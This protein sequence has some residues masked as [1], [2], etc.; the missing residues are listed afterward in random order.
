MLNDEML[1]PHGE[2]LCFESIL[3]EYP[4]P[5]LQRDSY[6]NLNGL[7][8]YAITNTEEFP[9]KYQGKIAVP[10]P[11]ESVLSQVKCTLSKNEYLFYKR[12]FSLQNFPI[13][14]QVLLHFMAV[15]QIC[16]LYL[17]DQK[18]FHHEG[19]YLPFC[20]N[21]K[22][23]LKKENCLIVRVVDSL[24][25]KFPYGKQRQDHHG[26]W[27]TPVSGIWQ[28]VFIESVAEDYIRELTIT[29]DYDAKSVSIICHSCSDHFHLSL[30]DP[31]GQ[32]LLEEENK[33]GL[34]QLKFS[35]IKSWSPEHP[36]LY[37]FVVKTPHDRISSYFGFRKFHVDQN[38]F[39]LNNRPYFIHAVLDQ[40]YYSDG[41][42]T[43]ASYQA[44]QDDLLYIRQLGFNAIR[45]HIKIEP[46][47]F[48]YLCDK[49]GILLLQDFVNNSPYHFLKDTLL[50]T[51][52]IQKL[53]DQNRKIPQANKDIFI[54]TAK[55]TL[56]HLYNVV[57]LAYYTI[58]NEGWGQFDADRM[59][60]MVSDTDSTRII[61]ATSGWFSQN[62]SDVDSRHIYFKK[63]KIVRKNRPVM[64]SEFGGYSYAVKD[65][66]YRPGRSYGYRFFKE[67]AAFV[68]AFCQLY[69]QEI[70][71]LKDQL[72]GCVY[73]QLSDVE[74]ETNGLL[75]YDRKVQKIKKEDVQTLFTKLTGGNKDD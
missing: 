43:P 31:D 37:T 4:R 16:D 54:N 17:N 9:E 41:I 61:D 67:Q 53:P 52:G 38:G 39:Y 60:K 56:H 26:M 15:D 47:Y 2:K 74:E 6:L 32:L 42:Y 11:I 3:P 30:S 12:E 35:E 36:Y 34:F 22:P 28:T 14:D 21:I 63:I 45:K 33:T 20:V 58:F 18:I 24:D 7:W 68:K 75:T 50:P 59:Y 27:Y 1:T 46:L 57:S 70:L 73:T 44:Y 51:I 25:V 62:D 65:H 72:M 66:T 8:D 69:E 29:P 13:S 64:I 48:Y 10:F 5:Q 55:Q 40:G 19:G 71:P 49:L 23:F